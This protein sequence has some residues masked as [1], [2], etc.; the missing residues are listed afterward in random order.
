[1]TT[2]TNILALGTT[3]RQSLTVTVEQG[4]V[5]SVGVFSSAAAVLALNE[6]FEVLRETPGEPNHI[7]F[8][9]DK[10]RDTQLYGPATYHVLSPITSVP[11]GVFKEV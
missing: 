2:K 3:A 4:D 5:V 7:C 8:L 11:F 6:R 1:M 9:T 10:V